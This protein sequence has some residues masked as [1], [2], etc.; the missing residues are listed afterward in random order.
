MGKPQEDI[1][2]LFRSKGL[3]AVGGD[4]LADVIMAQ[5]QRALAEGEELRPRRRYVVWGDVPVSR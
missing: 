3:A 5:N 1:E 2:T 4:P